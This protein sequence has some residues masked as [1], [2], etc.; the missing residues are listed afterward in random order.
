MR[1]LK[2]LEIPE[3][4]SGMHREVLGELL[5]RRAI[6][7]ALNESPEP[8]TAHEGPMAAHTTGPLSRKGALP[9][10]IAGFQ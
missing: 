6:P 8:Q 9:F 7:S 4:R 2:R 5:Q 1:F 3:H 10:T